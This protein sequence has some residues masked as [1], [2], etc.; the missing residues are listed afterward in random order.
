MIYKL[1]G[2]SA[3]IPTTAAN[4]G[5]ATL[6]RLVNIA[7]AHSTVQTITLTTSADA[8]I[9]SV[10]MRG[11]ETLYIAKEATDKIAVNSGTNVKGTSV[12]I[13]AG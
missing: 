2:A 3:N 4:F 9:G 7:D 8:A 5:S 1:K 10:L 12:A 11:G 6:I 13:W